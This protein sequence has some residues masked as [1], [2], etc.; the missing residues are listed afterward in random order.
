[1]KNVY[2][3]IAGSGQARNAQVQPG[4]TAADVLRDLGLP[5]YLLSRTPSG[6]FFANTESIY[7]KLT[8]GQKIFAS[9]KADVGGKFL[10]R[11]LEPILQH[12]PIFSG[13]RPT[14]PLRNTRTGNPVRVAPVPR[15]YWEDAGWS[16]NGNF[17]RG[18][19]QTPYGAY[20]G[21][22][23]Q[24]SPNEFV[25]SILRPPQEVLSSSHGLC[26]NP[27]RRGWFEVHMSTRPKDVSSGIIA[28]ERVIAESFRNGGL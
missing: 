17:Y 12:F 6:E 19:F 11:L 2:V 22:I 20:E 4:S 5:D 25:F 14:I 13:T 7:D 1:M 28:V 16:R 8:D 18:N 3:L 10:D 27:R 24:R 15:P 26:F 9:T 23:E 21:S